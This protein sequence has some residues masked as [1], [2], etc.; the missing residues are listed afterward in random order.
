MRPPD[1]RKSYAVLVGVGS[2]TDDRHP[3]VP[4]AKNNIEALRDILTGSR[5][6]VAPENC[7][8]VSDP[9]VPL[10]VLQPVLDIGAKATDLFFFY[11]VGHGFY[12]DS[13]ALLLTLSKTANGAFLQKSTSLNWDDLRPAIRDGVAAAR[14]VVVLDSCYS[15]IAAN[16]LASGTPPLEIE[17]T[18][19]LPSCPP[20]STIKA[21]EPYTFFTGALLDLLRSG[22]ADDSKYLTPKLIH[23][24]LARNLL[25]H[26][27]N[28]PLPYKTGTV[29]DLP[30]LINPAY[31]PSDELTLGNKFG[32]W[33]RKWALYRQRVAQDRADTTSKPTDAPRAQ[34]VPNGTTTSLAAP[35]AVEEDSCVEKDITK[36]SAAKKGGAGGGVLLIVLIILGIVVFNSADKHQVGSLPLRG[37][38]P[39]NDN[40]NLRY[41]LRSDAVAVDSTF[42]LPTGLQY[43]KI[44]TSSVDVT[45]AQGCR[46]IEFS[47]VIKVDG[48][49]RYSAGFKNGATG[50]AHISSTTLPT[51]DKV[52]LAGVGTTKELTVAAQATMDPGCTFN[53]TL[54]SFEVVDS[55]TEW[56]LGVV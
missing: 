36:I 11:Y 48:Q 38:A 8:L 6:C 22:V 25:R 2:Y 33:R 51:L 14:K 42:T 4:A 31:R 52:D 20:R 5:G 21:G 49:E 46:N 3:P 16:H 23:A 53:I 45:L 35:S 18:Y 56:L 9:A 26:R 29:E 43:R 47:L 7:T 37:E 50:S 28:L 27:W 30:L 54:S 12:T 10:D 32:R 24:E 19:L 15:G 55:D 41:E 44:R 1:P 40:G 17:G 39:V 13:D 34:T